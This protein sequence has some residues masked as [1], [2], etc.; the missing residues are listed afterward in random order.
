MPSTGHRVHEYPE[1]PLREVHQDSHR[2]I[3]RF[4]RQ[5]LEVVTIVHFRQELPPDRMP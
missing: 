3:Y 4:A 2:I 5:K 1:R